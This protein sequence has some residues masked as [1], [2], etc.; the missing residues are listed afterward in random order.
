MIGPTKRG[1]KQTIVPID[2]LGAEG[3]YGREPTHEMTAERLFERQW[4]LTLLER[5]LK[6][7]EDESARSGKTALFELL[8]PALQGDHMAP[9]YSDIAAALGMAEGAVRVAA[10]RLR[11][12]YREL[13]RE[14]VGRTT[15]GAAGIDDE[16]ADLLAALGAG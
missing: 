14:E 4:A 10:H 9:S 3:R 11:A 12:R 8:R 7:L 2:G 1:G 13:L 5:V 6:R 15:D 16:I